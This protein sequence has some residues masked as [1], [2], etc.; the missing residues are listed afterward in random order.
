MTKV[1]RNITSAK[2]NFD[3]SQLSIV[4]PSA[5]EGS[6]M[7]TYGPKS[8]IYLTEKLTILD[9]QIKLLRHIFPLATIILVT[10][11]EAAKVISHSPPNLIHIENERHETTNVSRSIGIG[12][13]AV[14]TSNVLIFYGDVVCN[15]ATFKYNFGSQSL[16]FVDKSNTMT[17]NE[18]GCTI[19]D[20]YIEQMM[21]DMPLKWAQIFYVAGKELAILRNITCDPLHEKHFGFELINEII[22]RGGKFLAASPNGM[23]V[24][25]VDCSKDLAIAQSII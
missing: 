3:S 25:D 13:R 22:N 1:T 24:N 19:V 23:K 5:G 18:V 10:G 21:Y 2:N 20:G 7:K 17:E 16:V 14:L 8:L 4:I 6:R 12:L 15:K 9:Y 11:H